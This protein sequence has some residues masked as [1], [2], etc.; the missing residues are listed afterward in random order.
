MK[1]GRIRKHAINSHRI[2]NVFDFAVA[3]RFI[4]AN[5]LVLYL[6]VNAARDVN[7]ARIGNTLK[8]RSDI[9]AIAENV[10]CFDDNVA[11]IDTNPILD[12][13]F[14]A[15]QV[16]FPDADVGASSSSLG[17]TSGGSLDRCPDVA[18]VSRRRLRA[19]SRVTRSPDER[20][21]A[22]SSVMLPELLPANDAW[23]LLDKLHET[24]DE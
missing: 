23:Q 5:Q 10:V 24:F 21:A 4:P 9:D 2:G 20:S 8:A 6:L 3:E 22:P 13:M 16:R 1:C 12:P 14:S 19:P 11:K 18:E 15:P 7:L 17:W